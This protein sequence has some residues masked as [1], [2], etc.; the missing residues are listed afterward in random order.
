MFPL[1]RPTALLRLLPPH[2]G[3]VA[4]ARDG[5]RAA[6]RQ[7]DHRHDLALAQAR[8][9]GVASWARLDDQ[10]GQGCAG[11]AVHVS[12]DDVDLLSRLTAFVVE[13]LADGEVCLVVATPRHLDGLRRHLDLAGLTETAAELLVTH[14]AA[15]LLSLLLRE[16]RPDPDLFEEHAGEPIRALLA[17]GRRLRAAGDLPGLLMSAGDRAGLLELEQMWDA[18]QQELGFPLLCAYP[19]TADERFVEQVRRTHS[20]LV[21]SVG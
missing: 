5:L 14:D 3:A 20:H 7:A 16:G 12:T 6:R 11:H 4:N 19:P 8:A 2:A 13:G 9:L 21:T 18:L 1:L 17:S 10:P 15:S